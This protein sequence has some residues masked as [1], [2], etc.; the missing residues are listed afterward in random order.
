[1][2]LILSLDD[3]IMIFLFLLFEFFYILILLIFM[4]HLISQVK[5]KYGFKFLSR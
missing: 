5:H 1:M 3:E 2:L 4:C